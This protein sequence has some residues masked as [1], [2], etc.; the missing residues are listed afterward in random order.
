MHKRCV[1]PF[2]NCTVSS[3]H[4]AREKNS[5]FGGNTQ[6]KKI[7][8]RSEE[9]KRELDV[10]DE[11]GEQNCYLRAQIHIAKCQPALVMHA[12]TTTNAHTHTHSSKQRN[13]E[14]I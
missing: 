5:Y 13:S 9:K 6:Y 7:E 2:Q 3:L 14:Q 1:K 8:E 10:C 4:P 12:H 11:H